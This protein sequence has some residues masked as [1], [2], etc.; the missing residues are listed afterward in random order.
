MK[1]SIFKIVRPG[2]NGEG[3][4][5]Q[6]RRPVFIPGAFV[7]ETVKAEILE[8]NDSYAR[9]RVLSVIT[10]ARSR[11]ASPCNEACTACPWISMRYEEQ[12]RLKKQLLC[13]AVYKYGNVRDTFVREIRPSQDLLHYRSACKLP[14]A[15]RNGLAVT[16]MYLPGTNH[17][18]EIKDCPVH[19]EKLEAIRK[20]VLAILHEEHFPAFDG[21]HGL[22]YLVIRR[23]D[24]KI[25]IALIT[26]RD[27]IPSSL[28]QKLSQLSEVTSLA[29]S[30]NTEKNS[31]SLFGSQAVTLAGLPYLEVKFCGFD[32]RLSAE[33]FFQ[34][35][36]TQAEALYR[37]A[38]SK[39]D[40]CGVLLEAYCGVGVM[41]IL[42]KDRAR[43][44]FGIES[45]PQAVENAKIN[46]D[47]NRVPNV[48]FLC[49]DAAHGLAEL[50]KT[51]EIDTLLADPPRAG[52]DE[53]MITAILASKIK[54]IVYISCN[55]AT[56]GKNIGALKRDFVL[57]TIIPF[58]MFPNTAH[59]ES[60]AVLTRV[61][62]SDRIKK[63]KKDRRRKKRKNHAL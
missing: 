3:I 11:C 63:D 40:P 33:S 4:A 26:G 28:V 12:L 31:V 56:L 17:F 8:E 13:E 2:I 41:S 45:I 55:P 47:L 6:N 44:I 29:Q 15:E 24:E 1:S 60:I 7:S 38:I 27:V 10:P 48:T 23:I 61:G 25:Q 54:K 9:A 32:L 35:N 5:Y 50:S 62:T 42:A 21:S 22:R 51:T 39:I 49:D 14:V 53:A 58:D 20:T 36:L 37:T 30:V 18:I 57:Q 59:V 52:M 19:D 46:A 34:L 43:K 16:G